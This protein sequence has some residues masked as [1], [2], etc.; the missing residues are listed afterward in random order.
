MRAD[1]GVAGDFWLKDAHVRANGFARE[2]NHLRYGPY[3]RHAPVLGFAESHSRCGAGTLAGQHTDA[4]LRE[5]GYAA[6][7]IAQL[8]QDKVVWSES[9][10]PLQSIT[11]TR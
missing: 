3:L 9:L 1:G 8:R 11:K 7:A 4:L 5:V 2:C 10:E 6:A